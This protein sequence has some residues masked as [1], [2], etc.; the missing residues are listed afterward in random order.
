[1]LH[2]LTI[3][4]IGLPGGKPQGEA[5]DMCIILQLQ[6]FQKNSNSEQNGKQN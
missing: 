4:G 1:M 5:C 3:L 6:I 2:P